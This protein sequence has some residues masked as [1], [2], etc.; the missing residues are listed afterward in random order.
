MDRKV[1]VEYKKL[2]TEGRRYLPD[3][4]ISNPTKDSRQTTEKTVP[5]VPSPKNGEKEQERGGEVVQEYTDNPIQE[6]KEPP[7]R[8]PV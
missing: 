5:T 2:T 8:D 4:C 7:S 3:V 6:V 1:S